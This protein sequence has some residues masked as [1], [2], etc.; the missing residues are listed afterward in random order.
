MAST[1]KFADCFNQ[2]LRFPARG[3]LWC[4]C[5]FCKCQQD[6]AQQFYSQICYR[7]LEIGWYAKS[8]W[9]SC[10]WIWAEFWRRRI[11][12]KFWWRGIGTGSQE[13]LQRPNS[14]SLT[15]ESLVFLFSSSASPVLQL[16]PISWSFY[17]LIPT[18]FLPFSLSFFKEKTREKFLHL[19][20]LS[21]TSLY[22]SSSFTLFYNCHNFSW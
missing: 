16:I 10:K 1:N 2:I 4:V 12:T 3:T 5:S 13:N 7:N 14:H 11:G 19:R 15:T 21:Y 9:N 20:K 22:F 6:Q 18:M 8:Y 17:A